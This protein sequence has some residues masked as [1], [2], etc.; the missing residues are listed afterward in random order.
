MKYRV[1]F[2]INNIPCESL[3][4]KEKD[5]INLVLSLFSGAALKVQTGKVSVTVNYRDE[6]NI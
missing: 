1:N 2:E 3:L 5:V 4:D 6:N